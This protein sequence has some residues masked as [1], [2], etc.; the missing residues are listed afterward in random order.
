MKNLGTKT[1]V[2]ELPP[3]VDWAGTL[4]GGAR[5]SVTVRKEINMRA[6]SRDRTRDLTFCARLCSPVGLCHVCC[7]NTVRYKNKHDLNASV[8]AGQWRTGGGAPHRSWPD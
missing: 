1:E 5:V 7:Q 3:R 6:G 8:I 2:K 4:T